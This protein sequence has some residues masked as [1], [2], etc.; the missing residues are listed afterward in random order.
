MRAEPK[1][2]R[3]LTS[4]AAKMMRKIG[5]AGNGSIMV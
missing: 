1:P 3:V 5:I 2:V 4:M